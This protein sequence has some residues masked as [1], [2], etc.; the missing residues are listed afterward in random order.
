M[1]DTGAPRE[2]L[3]C[4]RTYAITRSVVLNDQDALWLPILTRV[5]VI[6]VLVFCLNRPS[7]KSCGCLLEEGRT[8]QVRRS[9]EVGL[10]VG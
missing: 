7:V 9:V 8:V 4:A 3:T 2:R 5:V 10:P 6:G 1:R